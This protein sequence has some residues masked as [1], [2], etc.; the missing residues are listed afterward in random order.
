MLNIMSVC[1]LPKHPDEKPN[2]LASAVSYSSF[3]F[4]YYYTQDSKV[5]GFFLFVIFVTPKCTF[6]HEVNK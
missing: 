1:V 4:N 3:F 5:V 2:T 6:L